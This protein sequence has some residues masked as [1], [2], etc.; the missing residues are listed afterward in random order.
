MRTLE[1]EKTI[2]KI[3]ARLHESVIAELEKQKGDIYVR[4]V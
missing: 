1:E 4:R 3:V 2:E